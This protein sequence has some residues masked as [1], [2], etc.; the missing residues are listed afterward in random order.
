MAAMLINR[1]TGLL[2]FLSATAGITPSLSK[3]GR[4]D[5]FAMANLLRSRNLHSNNSNHDY[6]IGRLQ[7]PQCGRHY[8]TTTTPTTTNKDSAVS[9]TYTHIKPT[10][11]P[12]AAK[13]L[14]PMIVMHGLFGSKQNWGAMSKAISNSLGIEV[15]AVDLRNHGDSPHQHPHTYEAMSLDIEK[16]MNDHNIAGKAIILGHSMGG[17]VAMNFAL[18][19]PSKVHS[20]IVD[21]MSPVHYPLSGDFRAYT[22]ALKEIEKAGVKS[23]KEADQMLQKYEKDLGI[24]QFLLTNMK[25]QSQQSGGYVCRVPLDI[26]DESIE[27]MGKWPTVPPPSTNTSSSMGED[28]RQYVGPTLFISG[29]KS[30]YI[31]PKYYPDIEKYF[32]NSDIETLDTGHWVHAE[33]PNEFLELVKNFLTQ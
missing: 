10:K 2:C 15:Y 20:L 5:I 33:K 14:A 27:N 19:Y 26:I 7:K 22:R 11:P 6:T 1:P 9:L 28:T 21:D 3:V 24:R 12:A 25:K 8:S 32:P 16:F 13:L 4:R 29:A 23:Q 18:T 31:Q 30:S 17:K